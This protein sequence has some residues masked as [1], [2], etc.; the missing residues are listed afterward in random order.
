MSLYI[1]EECGAIENTACCDRN[2]GINPL[3]PNMHMMDMQG[4]G[5]E[6]ITKEF[7]KE[8]DAVVMLCSEC[9]TS[10]WHGE[11]NKN[12]AT[13]EEL[14]IGSFSKYNMITPYDH[15][16]GIVIKDNDAPHGYSLNYESKLL[17]T[18]FWLQHPELAKKQNSILTTKDTEIYDRGIT[19]N[20]TKRSARIM[21]A[22]MLAMFGSD[23]P[24]LSSTSRSRGNAGDNTPTETD[25]V[26]L[27]K[28]KLKREIKEL[29]RSNND[30]DLLYKLQLEYKK[31]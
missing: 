15:K 31:I 13:E 2:A 12:Y 17:N 7:Y 27:T 5:I 20:N 4:H 23:I 21:L 8:A 25:L 30:P 26:A 14:A 24:A 29:K 22:G 9:N 11:F 16:D 28:A 18:D 3:Y 6:I 10:V 19:I 1:C